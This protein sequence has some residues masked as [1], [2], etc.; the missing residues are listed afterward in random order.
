M[1]RPGYDD[2]WLGARDLTFYLDRKQIS[3]KRASL[4]WRLAPGRLWQSL[5]GDLLQRYALASSVNDF[6]QAP[7]SAFT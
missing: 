3:V 5:S 6:G 2:R 4:S 1:W 7:V